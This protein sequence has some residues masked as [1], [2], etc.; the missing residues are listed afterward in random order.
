MTKFE[1]KKKNFRHDKI[2][3]IREK[4]SA[5]VASFLTKRTEMQ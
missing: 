4:F 1:K 5:N 2:R 3:Y